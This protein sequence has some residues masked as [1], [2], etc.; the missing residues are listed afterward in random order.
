[1]EVI[2]MGDSGE[3]LKTEKQAVQALNLPVRIVVTLNKLILRT[4]LLLL[5]WEWGFRQKDWVNVLPA[6]A[7]SHTP[8]QDF[9]SHEVLTFL[10]LL[11]AALATTPATCCLS[12]ITTNVCWIPYLI[13]T[14][15]FWSRCCHYSW[16]TV[17]EP[18]AMKGWMTS[19]PIYTSG[20]WDSNSTS[21]YCFSVFYDRGFQDTELVTVTSSLP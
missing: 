21:L 8:F 16:L 6:L 19:Y 4:G 15:T 7:L 9:S 2:P 13:P 17:E 18:K 10:S 11:S 3:R 1:M 20:A 12:T 14:T 5:I